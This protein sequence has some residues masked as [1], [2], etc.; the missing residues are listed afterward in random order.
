MEI[1][2]KNARDGQLAY[3]TQQGQLFTQAESIS[4]QHF[5]SRYFGNSYQISAQVNLVNGAATVL[6]IRNND[7]SRDAVFSYMR[8]QVV[9][10]TTVDDV[11]N[12]FSWGTGTT[13]DSG[14]SVITPKNMNSIS[15]TA[16]QVTV[17]SGATMTGTYVESERWYPQSSGQQNTFNKAGAPIMG[18][19]DSAEIRFVGTNTTGIANV[20]VTFMMI[21]SL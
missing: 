5:V 18:L 15:G 7:A 11:N 2:I 14:G 1:N 6:H 13:V 12:Y 21:D 19:G 16:A 4:Q 8:M 10:A 20:R 9:G 17:T 3:V